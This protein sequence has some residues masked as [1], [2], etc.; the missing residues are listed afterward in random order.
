MWGKRL[1]LSGCVL[2]ICLRMFAPVALFG[3]SASTGLVTGVVTDP[4]AAAIPGATVTLQQRGT[5]ATQVAH[6]DSEGRYVFP[7]VNPADYTLTIAAPGF[8]TTVI[9]ELKVEVQKSSTVNM[10]LR[11]G[12]AA[13]TVS[14]SEAS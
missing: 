8:A 11:I 2:V 13:Q 1:I 6:T 10:S 3:Q 7:A 5:S 14:V 12:E 4:S 9:N